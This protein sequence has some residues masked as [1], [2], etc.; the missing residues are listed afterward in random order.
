MNTNR[1]Y[2]VPD[3]NEHIS[4]CPCCGR[5][6]YSGCGA[7]QSTESTLAD[8]WYRWT[9]GHEGRFELAIAFREDGEPVDNAGVAVVSSRIQG[10]NLVYTVVGPENS[11]WSDFG[12]YGKVL[13]RTAV[14]AQ[15]TDTNLFGIV[16]AICA[17]EQRL[18]N[19][20]LASGLHA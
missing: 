11:S 15:A 6:Q 16:D 1:V 3:G 5:P 19:R 4:A 10:G 14:I 8:Y 20:I 2:A 13:D 7:L 12:V 17:N 9:E 18:S